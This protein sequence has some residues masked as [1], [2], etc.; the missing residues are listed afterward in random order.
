MDMSKAPQGATHWAPETND[1]EES[2][3][4]FDGQSWSGVNAYWADHLP[5]RWYGY[6]VS[7]KRPMSDLVELAK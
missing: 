5:T 7:L 4:K 2:W 6:G 3:Y 1:Y